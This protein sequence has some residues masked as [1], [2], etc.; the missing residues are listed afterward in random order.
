M[1]KDKLTIEEKFEEAAITEILNK[2]L[3]HLQELEIEKSR[4]IIKPSIGPT[5][6]YVQSIRNGTF[7][8]KLI[9][10]SGEFPIS[11]KPMPKDDHSICMITGL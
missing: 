4:E 9:H 8:S 7:S 6:K 1:S 2:N 11:K 3:N 10:Q 5:I